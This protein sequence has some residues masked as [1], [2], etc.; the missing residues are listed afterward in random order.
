MP[1]LL[2]ACHSPAANRAGKAEHMAELK[3]TTGSLLYVDRVDNRAVIAT[4]AGDSSGRE[5]RSYRVG[6]KD[7][8]TYDAKETEAWGKYFNYSMQYDWVAMANG[9]SVHA[10]FFQPLPVTGKANEGILVFEVPAGSNP[11]TLVYTPSYRLHEQEMI[12]LHSN[13]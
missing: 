8:L 7:S 12:V 4:D 1:L 3:H 13:K 2:L 5:F 11:D 9:D 6:I 10:A